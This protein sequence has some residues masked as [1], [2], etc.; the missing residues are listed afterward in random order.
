MIQ[1]SDAALA[2]ILW[3]VEPAPRTIRCRHSS[4][5]N[6]VPLRQAVFDPEACRCGACQTPLLRA[7]DIRSR[8]PHHKAHHR[9][10]G[11]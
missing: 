10:N 11:R 5:G 6:R 4:K 8:E 2:D 3:P 7:L 1:D 9:G